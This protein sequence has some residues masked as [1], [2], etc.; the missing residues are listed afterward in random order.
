MKNMSVFFFNSTEKVSR[1]RPG[2]V[3]QPP[4]DM[5]CSQS[6][7]PGHG[8]LTARMP[9]ELLSVHHVAC[10]IPIYKGIIM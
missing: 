7:V 2:V 4:N 9:H 3:C 5:T 6:Q 10:H 1:H 8:S